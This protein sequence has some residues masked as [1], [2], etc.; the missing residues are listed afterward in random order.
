MY[1]NLNIYKKNPYTDQI[2]ESTV[3]SLDEETAF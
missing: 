2:Y 3:H 1:Q